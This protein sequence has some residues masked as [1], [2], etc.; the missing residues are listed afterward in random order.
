MGGCGCVTGR[1]PSAIAM[2]I[3]TVGSVSTAQVGNVDVDVVG[4]LP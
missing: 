1:V 4:V 2:A 3:I